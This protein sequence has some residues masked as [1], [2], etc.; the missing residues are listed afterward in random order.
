MVLRE[1]MDLSRLSKSRFANEKSRCIT[2]APACQNKANHSTYD[3][4]AQIET[5]MGLMFRG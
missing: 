4:H 5:L 1:S 2:S 3:H